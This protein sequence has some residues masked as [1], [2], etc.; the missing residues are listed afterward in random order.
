MEC[1]KAVCLALKSARMYTGIFVWLKRLMRLF[2]GSPA[3][4]LQYVVA[5]RKC[6]CCVCIFVARKCAE[7]QFVMWMCSRVLLTM[8]AT[9]SWPPP[10]Y[11]VLYP[12]SFIGFGVTP[13]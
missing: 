13:V 11:L 4:G 3:S 5:T 12:Y 1:V 10:V 7:G 6:P 9:P 8:T 2:R